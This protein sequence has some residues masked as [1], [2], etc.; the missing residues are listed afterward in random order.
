MALVEKLVVNRSL[1]KLIFNEPKSN[2]SI[3]QQ[4]KSSCLLLCNMPITS[5]GGQDSEKEC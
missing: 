4:G 3:W 1:Y 2:L 5:G